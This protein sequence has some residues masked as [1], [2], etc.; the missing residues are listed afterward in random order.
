[1]GF[2]KLGKSL[3]MRVQGLGSGVK[4]LGFGVY[5]LESLKHT[6][7]RKRDNLSTIF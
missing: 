4:G 1:M 6:P 2:P 7:T 3:G 5:G